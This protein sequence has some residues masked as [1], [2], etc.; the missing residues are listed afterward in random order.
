MPRTVSFD[1]GP[2]VFLGTSG[3]PNSAHIRISASIRER[4]RLEFGWATIKM[5]SM[6]TKTPV[7]CKKIQRTV[8]ERGKTGAV[9]NDNKRAKRRHEKS[10][11]GNCSQ[12]ATSPTDDLA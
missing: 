9:K 1:L 11:F 4:Q 12:E 2:K 10:Y 5:S 8:S 7:M 3:T 6:Y